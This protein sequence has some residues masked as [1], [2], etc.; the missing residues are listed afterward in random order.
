[1]FAE[2]KALS[3]KDC[4]TVSASFSLSRPFMGDFFPVFAQRG[5]EPE[6]EKQARLD[7]FSN[8]ASISSSDYFGD[9]SGGQGSMSRNSNSNNNSNMSAG[10][11]MRGLSVQAKQDLQSVGDLAGKIGGMASTFVR[12][13]GRY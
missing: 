13:L 7:K 5:P 6:H 2:A 11:L 3:P 12:D 10:D 1:M 9:G 4:Q 8:S